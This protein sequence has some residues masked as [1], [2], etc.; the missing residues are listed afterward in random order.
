MTYGMA[1]AQSHIANYAGGGMTMAIDV[2]HAARL[3]NAAPGLKI[4]DSVMS[5]T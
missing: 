1:V 3:L 2:D 5:Q 4:S